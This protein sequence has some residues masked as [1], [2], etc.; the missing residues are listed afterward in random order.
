MVNVTE[1][2]ERMII[3]DMVGKVLTAQGIIDYI[4]ETFLHCAEQYECQLDI[5]D[6]VL[7]VG[8]TPVVFSEVLKNTDMLFKIVHARFEFNGYWRVCYVTA[9]EI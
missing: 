5:P 1:R 4:S 2:A 3:K 7:F 9:E 8:T 6:I